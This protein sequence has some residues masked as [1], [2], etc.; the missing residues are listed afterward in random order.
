MDATLL[1]C[2]SQVSYLHKLFQ[3]GLKELLSSW[4][5]LWIP[6]RRQ[7]KSNWDAITPRLARTVL[8]FRVNMDFNNWLL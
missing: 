2:G 5:W 3:G 4:C 1:H 8:A 7:Q 6:A